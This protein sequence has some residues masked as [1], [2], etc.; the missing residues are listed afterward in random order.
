MGI[1]I[2]RNIFLPKIKL[3]AINNRPAYQDQCVDLGDEVLEQAQNWFDVQPWQYGRPEDF[4]TMRECRISMKRFIVEN[5]NFKDHT[6]SW[7]LI[8]SFVMRWIMGYLITFIV[9]IIIEYYR[10]DLSKEI[11]LDEFN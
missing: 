10:D 2:D 8:P 9:K 5:I 1:K 3:F 4:D 6:K 7:N 11:G